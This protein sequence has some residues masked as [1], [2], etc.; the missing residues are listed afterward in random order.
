[1]RRRLLMGLAVTSAAVS[2][3]GIL[4][5]VAVLS[6]AGEAAAQRG[7]RGRG[8]R[9]T[10]AVAAAPE[11]APQSEA[12]APALGELRWGMNPEETFAQVSSLVAASYRERLTKAAR[13][14]AVQEDRLRQE[15]QVETRRVRSSFVRFNGQA[16]GWDTS[17][18]RDEFTHGNNESMM[19]WRDDSTHSQ[20]YY[21]FINDRLWKIYQAFDASVFAGATFDQFGQAIQGRFGPGVERS[22]A[23]VEGRQASRWVEW[24]DASTRLRAVDQTR[25]Y[26]FFCLVFE[27]K[28]TLQQLPQLRARTVQ[29]GEQGHALVES[30]LRD[31][32]AQPGGTEA[33]DAHSDIADRLTGQMRRRQDAPAAGTG[34]AAGGAASSGSAR[35]TGA[36]QAPATP[37]GVSAADDPLGGMDL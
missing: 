16:G 29:R 10:A 13:S 37:G 9:R 34:A 26:G 20:R 31:G 4:S 23:L 22:G 8:A 15:L 18:V 36:A 28:A 7:R 24:Q 25:F 27:D 35:T 11:E 2:A 17:F 19:L 30:V 21:F 3:V 1:M 5:M 14:D 32:D 12:I 6:T 33:S